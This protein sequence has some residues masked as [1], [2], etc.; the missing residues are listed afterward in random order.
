MAIDYNEII[1]FEKRENTFDGESFK[2]Y[3]KIRRN[4]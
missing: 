2:K 4:N 3:L 1:H